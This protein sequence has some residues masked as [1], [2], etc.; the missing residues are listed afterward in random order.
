MLKVLLFIA[1]SIPVL[2]LL[3]S[4]L[5]RKPA[6]KRA[7]VSDFGRHVGYLSIGILVVL[8]LS[9]AWFAFR[10]LTGR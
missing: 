3:K 6:G 4:L 9:L 5:F 7:P 2:L 10:T 8:G 1:S